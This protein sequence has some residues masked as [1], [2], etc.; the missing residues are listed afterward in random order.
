M[1]NHGKKVDQP[2]EVLEDEENI[3]ESSDRGSKKL[4]NLECESDM[5]S[6][7]DEMEN[8]LLQLLRKRSK[9]PEDICSEFVQLSVSKPEAA[10]VKFME[11][12]LE[13]SERDF[14]MPEVNR[15]PFKT[16][17]FANTG[18]AK[19]EHRFPLVVRSS[20]CCGMDASSFLDQLMHTLISTSV[21]LQSSFLRDMSDFLTVATGS[22]VLPL[23][24][25]STLVA[26]KMMTA[27]NDMIALQDERLHAL[28]LN[29]FGGVFL[30][31]MRDVADDIR[32]L[33]VAECGVWLNKF[34]QS[35]IS[36]TRL[37]Y[38]FHAFE[39]CSMKVW[40]ASLYSIVRLEK[41]PKL[42][43]DCLQLG[44]KFRMSL[45]SLSLGSDA[46]L[47]EMAI[48]LL[49][50]FQRVM[51]EVIDD[52]MVEII[53]QMAFA[54][55]R[56][57]AQAAAE[58]LHVRF[59]EK[60]TATARMLALARLFIKFF[61][62][63][64]IPY[65]IDA[66]Y[67]VS[68]SLLDW[69]TM[70]E[71]LLNPENL[72]YQEVTVI[73]EIMA[74]SVRQAVTGELPPGRATAT[75]KNLPLV[76]A[77]EQ[78]ATIISPVLTTLLRQ[79]RMEPLQMKFLLDLTLH[80]NCSNE[81]AEELL[82]Q[83]KLLILKHTELE[84]MQHCA[85]TLLHLF[86]KYEEVS[87]NI[88]KELMERAAISYLEADSAWQLSV[89]KMQKSRL[90][91]CSKRLLIALRVVSAVYECFNL[92]EF[93][94]MD[95]VQVSLKRA[96]RG[97]DVP[98]ATFSDEAVSLC[99]EICY[100]AV[101]WDLK[102]IQEEASAGNQVDDEC[103]ALAEQ[104]DIFFLAALHIIEHSS[105]E[106]FCCQAFVST[107]DLLVLFSDNLPH[108]GNPA[109]CSLQYK[110]SVHEL[111]TLEDFAIRY[112][113]S[114]AAKAELNS[115]KESELSVL[116]H[117]KR[118]VLAGFCKLCFNSVVP[119]L[120]AASVLQY[121]EPFHPFY[122]DLLLSTMERCM[123]I[124]LTEFG[125]TLMQSLLLMYKRILA[126][127]DSTVKAGN[128]LQFGKL[129]SMARNFGHLLSSD[130]V[131]TRPAVLILHRAGI[132]Y[133]TDG[134][135]DDSKAPENLLYLKVLRQLVPLLLD[136]DIRE[137]V[138]DLDSTIKAPSSEQPS[139]CPEWEPLHFYR[140]SLIDKLAR[141][142]Y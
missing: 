35:Y 10:L 64:R 42:R 80:M 96:V 69:S 84:V 106:K 127:Y 90:N 77:D 87:V 74:R 34:P 112:A 30:K 62:H 66:F 91:V 60:P 14:I 124:N 79:Y 13:A 85:E 117:S 128:S 52:E 136:E 75:L 18:N 33:C 101:C 104:L 15:K 81:Q 8:S 47:A 24:R 142:F 137:L 54:I 88:R 92:S 109:L 68:D 130:V 121:Y 98:E 72:T 63:E 135:V 120:R 23:R 73:I 103:L 38:L 139:T 126:D 107:C 4:R 57:V 36:R 105:E 115:A 83:I 114:E 71:M 7:D 44:Y 32:S 67:G 45:L 110:P 6:T 53:E 16:G 119:M 31:R 1:N 122:E 134:A 111:K 131:K 50:T 25:T 3:L 108:S 125:M 78:V 37:L 11:F 94:V 56:S 129:L 70:V 86:Q 102:R 133:A 39:D 41:K 61:G 123:F 19:V 55:D 29:L 116:L 89:K 113:F 82:D 99:L 95:S 5:S 100:V 22:D 140:K 21:I 43:A 58:L 118:R 65:L 26:M 59:N 76:E 48:R 141:N 9:N 132:R 20:R 12:V 93:Q 27:L 49:V 28:W 97:N 40:E 46:T 138:R 17:I 51:P 2:F